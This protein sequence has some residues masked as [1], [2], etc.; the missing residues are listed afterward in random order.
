MEL[1][2]VISIGYNVQK[3]IKECLSSVALQTYSNIEIIFVDD[4]STDETGE[5]VKKMVQEDSRLRYIYQENQG[6]NAARKNGFIHAKGSYCI[7]IDGD[8]KLESCA[9]EQAIYPLKNS[10]YDFICFDYKEFDEDHDDILR[11]HTYLN[12]EFKEYAYLNSIL[13]RKQAHFIWNKLYKKAFLEKMNFLDIPSITMGDDLAANVRMGVNKPNVLA[14]NQKLYGY[15][16][17]PVSVSRKPNK[18][19]LE[20]ITMM[21]DIEQQLKS[22]NKYEEYLELVDFNYFLNFYY[23]VVRNKYKYTEIQKQ[24]YRAWKKRNVRLRS[25]KYIR[26][27]MSE[28]NIL[29]RGL[30]YVINF[31]D[32][33]EL[34]ITKVYTRIEGLE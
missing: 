13:Q 30:I 26:S 19:Y 23:Y 4:G 32:K 20:L 25:N 27:L 18:T 15:R 8:D 33:I 34:V 24:I 9:V 1:V 17:N 16:K 5:I 28:C 22:I 11:E 2:S 31:S 21:E 29:I 10:D 3:T 14:I 7:F 12:G 6:A